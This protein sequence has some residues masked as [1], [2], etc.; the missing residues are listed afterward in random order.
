MLGLA[1]GFQLSKTLRAFGFQMFLAGALLASIVVVLFRR[2]TVGR[3]HPSWSLPYEV[4]VEVVRRFMHNG[5]KEL[6]GDSPATEAPVPRRPWI[7]SRVALTREKLAGQRAEIHTPA[8]YAPGGPTLLYWHGGGYVSCSPRTHR[9]LLSAIALDAGVRVVAPSY[10]M[11]PAH[12]F[13]VAADVAVECYRALIASGVSPD[14]LIVGGDSA[15]GGLALSMLLKLRDAGEALPR[16]VML[17]SPWVD[18]ESTGDSVLAHARYDYLS[19]AML[20]Q[21]SRWYAGSES[22]RHPMLSPIHA[23]LSGLPPMFVL[24]GGLELFRSENEL[25]VEKLRAAGTSVTHEVGENAVHV[26]PL[27]AIVSHQS[28]QAIRTL[29][30]FIREQGGGRPGA[31]AIATSQA[32]AS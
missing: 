13:P 31:E 6:N 22:L 30:G 12:V 11:A 27:L 18:L 17:L 9:D 24:T 23:D 8:G 16:S 32:I 29:S 19:P 1:G 15:G 25:F 7:G 21:A 4:A 26:F 20:G 3:A 10:P 5:I 2:L 14:N 28:R